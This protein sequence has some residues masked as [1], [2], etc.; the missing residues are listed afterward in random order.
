MVECCEQLYLVFIS[1]GRK[2]YRSFGVVPFVAEIA[3]RDD[4]QYIQHTNKHDRRE[5]WQERRNGRVMQVL[6]NIR[7]L[8][9]THK[10]KKK[11]RVL[12]IPWLRRKYFKDSCC[13]EKKKQLCPDKERV[14]TREGER[15][16]RGE[17]VRN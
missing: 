8:P 12:E 1:T 5:M 7:V 9:R 11:D 4:R 16:E 3:V 15:K 14:K 10:E 6:D 17:K 13:E 2:G